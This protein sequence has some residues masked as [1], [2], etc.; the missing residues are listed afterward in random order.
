MLKNNGLCQTGIVFS[1][2]NCAEVWGA[3]ELQATMCDMSGADI[4]A[5]KT[6]FYDRMM[7]AP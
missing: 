1:Y 2:E 5:G 4:L 3:Q 6:V 7:K